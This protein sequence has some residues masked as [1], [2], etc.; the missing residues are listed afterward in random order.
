MEPIDPICKKL[1]EGQACSTKTPIDL[2][3]S[4]NKKAQTCTLQ[5]QALS[6]KVS[7]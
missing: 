6:T 4:K 2:I 7:K 3:V 1:N 5:I